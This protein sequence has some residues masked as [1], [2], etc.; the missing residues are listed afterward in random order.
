MDCAPSSCRERSTTL[1][2]VEMPD[3]K[4]ILL[5]VLGEVRPLVEIDVVLEDLTLLDSESSW[6]PQE[7]R[8]RALADGLW[9]RRFFKSFEECLAMS[10]LWMTLKPTFGIKYLH[11]VRMMLHEF[12]GRPQ[13]APDE[14][15]TVKV[16]A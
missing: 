16:S 2:S 13:A 11:H 12:H 9:R 14:P 3:Q 8:R 15:I 1:V 6:W 7:N 4:E 5:N 10:D